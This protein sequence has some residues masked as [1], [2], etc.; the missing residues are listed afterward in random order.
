MIGDGIVG[1][2]QV[3]FDT[4]ISSSDFRQWLCDIVGF[5]RVTLDTGISSSHFR[6]WVNSGI[7]SSN[8]G[9]WNFP[10]VTLI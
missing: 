2:L 8:F 5:L 1:F 9:Y 10:R 7:S 4:E 6:Q 3:T